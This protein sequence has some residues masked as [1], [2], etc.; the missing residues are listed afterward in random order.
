MLTIFV[1]IK[2]NLSKKPASVND[3]YFLID[4]QSSPKVGLQK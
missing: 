3:D 4:G 2:A 1:K